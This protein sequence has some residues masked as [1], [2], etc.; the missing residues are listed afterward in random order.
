MGTTSFKCPSCGAGIHFKPALK[1]FKCDYCLSEYTEEEIANLYKEDKDTENEET[2]QEEKVHEGHIDE[3][4]LQSY[5]CNSCGAQVVTD[6]TTTATFCYYCHNPVIV[7]GRL[8]G[9]FR[10]RKMIPFTIDKEKAKSSFLNWAGN[11]KFVPKDF[12]SSSQLEKITG[13]Y[14]PYWWVDTK[15]QVDY[16]G[17]GRNIRVWRAGD[18][19]YTETKKYEIVRQGEIDLNNV[20]ELAFTKIDK[21]LLNGILPYRENESVEFSMPYLSGFFAEQYDIPKEDAEP[22]IEGQINRYYNYM[23]NDLVSG[24]D[25][26]NVIRDG[27]EIKEKEWN[28]TL[29][30]AWILT[31]NYQGKTYIFAVNGQ[32]GKSYG[33]LPLSNKRLNSAFGIIFAATFLVLVLGGVLIW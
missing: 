28:Y 22:M 20:G 18:V 6:D 17:E 21:A 3:E 10:P 1:K 16:L 15:A 32:T 31:Y 33:E 2:H 9:E 14:L 12:T 29:L 25:G 19:E 30:P 13:V 5:S 8:E 26:V 7:T 24:Y 23:I 4:R 27:I 11:K